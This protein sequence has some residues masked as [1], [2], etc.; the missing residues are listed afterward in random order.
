MTA[1][2]TIEKSRNE[3]RF[4]REDNKYCFID[5]NDLSIH[6]FSGKVVKTYPSGVKSKINH[7]QY[8]RSM[9]GAICKMLAN[10]YPA[11]LMSM[12][13]RIIAATGCVS[14]TGHLITTDENNTFNT[15]KNNNITEATVIKI[16]R[17]QI[18]E[19]DNQ[20]TFTWSLT[21]TVNSL[22]EERLFG[23]NG[24]YNALVK[25][26]GISKVKGVYN[27][28]QR[29][30]NMTENNPNWLYRILKYGEDALFS[31]LV[32]TNI[33]RGYVL[34]DMITEIV[35]MCDEMNVKLPKGN[36]LDEYELLYNN[37]ANWKNAA[38]QEAFQEVQNTVSTYEN[39]EFVA[40]VPMTIQ[41][42]IQEGN[43]QR[44]CA[45]GYWLEGYG[46]TVSKFNRGMLFVR[47]KANPE[48]PYIT[49]DFDANT[50]TIK[51]YLYGCNARVYESAELNFK[52]ELQQHLYN[53]LRG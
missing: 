2:Y 21:R 12:I 50:G 32:A 29:Y 3:L 6:G 34:D 52:Q 31:R 27:H 51:Q 41:E 28:Y 42:V 5:L 16:L 35:R 22:M 37:Y 20:S 40:L 10:E 13:E 1:Y 44:N 46:N 17:K 8:E 19:Q 15:M 53:C 39:E 4:I 14:Y 9:I 18:A 47:K 23:E 24:R 45:G 38:R 26:Y 43:A 25:E 7:M 30:Q 48:K 33:I 36:L 49:C 11:E